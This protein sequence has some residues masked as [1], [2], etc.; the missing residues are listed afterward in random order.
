MDKHPY[1]RTDGME[2]HQFSTDV[3]II[4]G[5]LAGLSAAVEAAGKG[6]KVSL[7]SKGKAG[8]SGNTV[9]TQ[10]NISVVWDGLRTDDSV[11]RFIED[12]LTGGGNLNDRDLVQALAT[13]ALEA[14]TW[15]MEQGVQFQKDKDDLLIK[16]SPGHSRFRIVRAV[17]VSKSPHTMGLG[18]SVPLADRA[19]ALGVEF[20]EN[21]VIISLLLDSGRVCGAIGLDKKEAAVCIVHAGSV[22]LAGGGAGGL[23]QLSTNARDVCGDSYAL[24]YQAGATL[25]D[26]EF[27][28][29]HPAVTVA[30]PRLVIST[31]PFADGAVLRNRLGEAYMVRYSPQAD[32]ATRDVMAR[33][34]FKE[35]AEGRGTDRGGVYVDFSAVPVEV[36]TKNYQDI[37]TAFQGAKMIEVAPAQHFM[38]GGIVIDP[39]CRSTVPGLWV[40][41]EAAGGLHGANRLAGN[42]LTEAALFGRRAGRWAAAECVQPKSRVLSRLFMEEFLETRF[43]QWVSTELSL[44]LEVSS[45]WSETQQDL[46]CSMGLYVGVI[47]SK[48]GL[49]QAKADLSNI[50]DRLNSQ[51]LRTYGDLLQ[52]CQQK[53]MVITSNL[54][55]DAAWQRSTSIGSHYRED[56]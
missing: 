55:V 10:N 37:W 24:G 45:S 1:E 28:Q 39:Q 5:G 36:M 32:M 29:F 54:I 26:M 27:I 16:G 14:I 53:M 47:R 23:F 3:L 34:N 52:Y 12:T 8:R 41:G 31:S 46:K 30:T 21:I 17:G 33:A 20:M 48:K 22:V 40:C 4:G 7:V 35:I 51:P 2:L 19:K 6:L 42:A 43:G 56:R 13:E 38:L 18:L 9:L 44:S 49:Q 25:R 15:L 50:A 11:E